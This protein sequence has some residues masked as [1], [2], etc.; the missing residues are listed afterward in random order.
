MLVERKENSSTA[1]HYY[2]LN[3]FVNLL[4]NWINRDSDITLKPVHKTVIDFG[5]CT[6]STFFMIQFFG[7]NLIV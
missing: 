2:C 7:V 1:N 3:L 4:R 5:I 6:V